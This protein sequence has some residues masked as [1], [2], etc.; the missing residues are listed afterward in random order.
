MPTSAERLKHG[1]FVEDQFEEF[2]RKFP[3]WKLI[4]DGQRRLP[5]HQQMEARQIFVPFDSKFGEELKSMLPSS[6]V[7]VYEQRLAKEGIPNGE[8][9]VSDFSCHLSGW[10]IFDAEI[11]SEMTGHPNITFELSGYLWSKYEQLKHGSNKVFIFAVGEQNFDWFYLFLDQI[12]QLTSRVLPGR[13]CAGSGR[14]FGLIPKSALTQKFE[15]LLWY[16]ETL[17]AK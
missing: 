1:H 11:K 14:P 12:P 2:M 16:Y 5:E 7:D 13:D 4:E 3:N 9:F 15:H 17:L 8:R 10:P 6:W